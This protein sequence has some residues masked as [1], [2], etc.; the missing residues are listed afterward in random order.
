MVFTIRLG[1]PIEPRNFHREFKTRCRKTGV[2]ETSVHTRRTCATLLAALDV[3][4]RV[5][6]RTQRHS[7]IAVTMN[8]HATV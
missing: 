2:R 7:Q 5:M 1:T 4:P 6:M 3:Q 8:I